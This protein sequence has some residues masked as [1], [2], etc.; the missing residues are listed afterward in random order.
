M[1]DPSPFYLDMSILLLPLCLPISLPKYPSLEKIQFI[2]GHGF[3]HGA[4]EANIVGRVVDHEQDSS[5]QLI[6]H[7]QVVQVCPLVVHTAVA[8]TPLHQGPEV[9]LVPG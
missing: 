8:A 5:Q 3:S 9:I 6:G 4:E 7:Q 2:I 1:I